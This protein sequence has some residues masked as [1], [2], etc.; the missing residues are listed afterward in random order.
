MCGDFAQN[1]LQRDKRNQPSGLPHL[2]KIL[3]R[4]GNKTSIH[5]FYD[6]DDIVRDDWVK[7]FIIAEIELEQ[8]AIKNQKQLLTE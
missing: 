8:N 2:L 7:E 1:D 5:E 4:M 3:E 6:Y